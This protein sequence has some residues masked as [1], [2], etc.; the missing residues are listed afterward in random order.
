LELSLEVLRDLLASLVTGVRKRFFQLEVEDRARVDSLMDNFDHL[1]DHDVIMESQVH[2]VII[3]AIVRELDMDA[4]VSIV[5]LQLL[6]R[7][8]GIALNVRELLS[9]KPESAIV[10][11]LVHHYN[12]SQA[13]NRLLSEMLQNPNLTRAQIIVLESRLETA[14]SSER[15]F[16]CLLG[17]LFAREPKLVFRDDEIN[18]INTFADNIS[19]HFNNHSPL[20]SKLCAVVKNVCQE[21]VS[22]FD[23]SSICATHKEFVFLA[24]ISKHSTYENG[25]AT[26]RT[27]KPLLDQKRK[28]ELQLSDA[29]LTNEVRE[30]AE[31]LLSEI[32]FR[33]VFAESILI[34]LLFGENKLYTNL[35]ASEKNCVR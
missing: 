34:V 13:A 15:L 4:T 14:V 18:R 8:R 28:L 19:M 2:D 31:R 29:H 9:G 25:I 16:R 3:G 20:D 11:E 24:D 5:E 30:L 27:L 33:T 35:I 26:L 6:M 32:A 12:Q 23:L 7:D 17:S 1:F 10:R 21:L 22:T